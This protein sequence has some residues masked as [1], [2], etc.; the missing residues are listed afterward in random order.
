LGKIESTA[1]FTN[2]RIPAGSYAVLTSEIGPVEEVV[3]AVWQRAWREVGPQ[4]LY[5]ADFEVYDQRAA[6][7]RNS[8]IDLYIRIRE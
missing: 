4:R 6:D 2:V 3:P 8:Q 5:K 1:N 7:P